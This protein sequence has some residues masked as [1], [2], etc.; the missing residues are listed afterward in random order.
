MIMVMAHFSQTKSLNSTKFRCWLKIN[1]QIC[2]CCVVIHVICSLD[3]FASCFFFTLYFF[4]LFHRYF[5]CTVAHYFYS[6]HKQREISSSTP[7][8][9]WP[10][11]ASS[12]VAMFSV[13]RGKQKQNRFF[14]LVFGRQMKCALLIIYLIFFFVI[15]FIMLSA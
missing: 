5:E 9:G 14:L 4:S 1:P 15:S 6:A 10:I 8:V 7:T 11:G 2:C 13:P 12:T 3:K